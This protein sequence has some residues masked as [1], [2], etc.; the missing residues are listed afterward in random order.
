MLL[1]FRSLIKDETVRPNYDQLLDDPFIKGIDQSR[2]E[3][4]A[5][6]CEVLT[7]MESNGVSPF[8]MDQPAQSWTD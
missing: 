6:V 1:F 2:S 8:T 4:A 7:E 5:Y 3:V